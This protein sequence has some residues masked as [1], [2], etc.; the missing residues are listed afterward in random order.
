[1]NYF[2]LLGG[3]QMLAAAIYEAYRG[4]AVLTTVFLSYAIANFALGMR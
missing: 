2:M 4:D 3:V 1:M